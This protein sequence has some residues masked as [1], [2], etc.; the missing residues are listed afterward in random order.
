MG[1]AISRMMPNPVYFLFSMSSM[2]VVLISYIFDGGKLV[3]IE[4][5][6]LKLFS[7]LVNKWVDKDQLVIVTRVVEPNVQKC[8]VAHHFLSLN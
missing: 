2:Q 1:V 3:L 6:L 8:E 4:Y 5:S 7:I